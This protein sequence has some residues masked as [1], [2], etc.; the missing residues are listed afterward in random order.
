MRTF[1]YKWHRTIGITAAIFIIFLA[2]SGVLL[3][4]TD[5]L[6]LQD[7]YINN[8]LLFKWYNIQ[9][10]WKSKS[11]VADQH[12]ITLINDHLYFN[13]KEI[14]NHISELY[15]VVQSG[16]LLFVAVDQTLF[17]LTTDGQIVEKISHA[18]GLPQT[19]QAI[20]LSTTGDIIIITPQGNY[21][22]DS[23]GTNWQPYDQ[24]PLTIS[25]I[26]KLPTELHKQLQH[27]HQ[28]RILSVERIILDIHS[29]R[30]LGQA[31]VLL[32]DLMACLTVLL[33]LSGIWMWYKYRQMG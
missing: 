15:G 1:I 20:G 28:S 27:L 12:W 26:K 33:S 22:A 30:I 7:K 8:S 3:S 5:M 6:K 23:Q 21:L 13:Q 4:H 25:N 10:I 29:G 11:F 16:E 9:P 31:G 32:I 17:I 24:A 18:H 2:I 14:A 19:I